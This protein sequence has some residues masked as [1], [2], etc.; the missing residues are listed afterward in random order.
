MNVNVALKCMSLLASQAQRDSLSIAGLTPEDF[1]KVVADIAWIGSDRQR[2]TQHFE[3]LLVGTIDAL[4]LPRFRMPAEWIAAGIAMFVADVNI[5]TAC[6]F[7]EKSPTVD[8]LARGSE[9]DVATSSQLFALT[10]LLKSDPIRSSARALWDKKVG[11]ALTKPI[12][13]KDGD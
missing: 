2:I 1:H 4:G 13:K 6:K 11:Y 10:L 9:Y 7:F 12:N 8:E 3:A 5:H